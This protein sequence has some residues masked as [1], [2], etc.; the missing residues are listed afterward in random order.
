MNNHVHLLL[1]VPPLPAGGFSDDELLN[2]LDAT[3][4]K[5]AGFSNPNTI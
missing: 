3:N 1:E 2:F 5:G 4:S